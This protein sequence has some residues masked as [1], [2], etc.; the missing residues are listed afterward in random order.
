MN[1]L[2]HMTVVQE[3]SSGDKFKR[4]EMSPPSPIRL[5]VSPRF[6]DFVAVAWP[7]AES[8][9]VTTGVVADDLGVDIKTAQ[10]LKKGQATFDNMVG[11][12]KLL[13]SRGVDPAKLPQLDPQASPNAPE[14]SSL[15]ERLYEARPDLFQ[16]KLRELRELVNALEVV[17]RES[18]GIGDPTGNE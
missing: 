8:V 3:M 4:Q 9:G 17:E 12:K 7:L 16:K 13:I 18:D 1:R 15:G 14:W 11:F 5:D 6:A 10:R 2:A